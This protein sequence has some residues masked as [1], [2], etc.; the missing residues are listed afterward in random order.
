VKRSKTIGVPDPDEDWSLTPLWEA[1]RAD[2]EARVCEL[3]AS[4][5]HDPNQWGAYDGAPGGVGPALG[6]A[7]YWELDDAVR[8]LLDAGAKPNESVN[9]YAVA[10]WAQSPRMLEVL[11]ESGADV[12]AASANN[13]RS[14][15]HLLCSRST[16][17][18]V[19]RAVELGANVHH[20]DAWGNTPLFEATSTE[21]AQV[22]IDAGTDAV[23][24]DDNGCQALFFAAMNGRRELVQLLLDAGCDPA[25]A[26]IVGGETPAD[27]AERDGHTVIAQLLRAAADRQR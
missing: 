17:D 23:A 4:G 14:L 12:N 19:R 20:R 2:D 15:L 18:T 8:C 11:V 27:M 22:L 10:G 24:M 26:S 16:A 13:A 6:Y 25:K 3:L 1:L 5:S 7:L 9:G 21:I